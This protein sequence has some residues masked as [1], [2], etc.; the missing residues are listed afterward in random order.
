MSTECGSRER[1]PDPASLT[2]A[3]LVGGLGL[4]LRSVVADR[5]KVMAP[6]AGRPFLASLL[7]QV[8]AAGARKAVLCTG[9]RAEQIE[10]EFGDRYGPLALAYSRETEPL[11]TA[12]AL[13]LAVPRLDSDPVLVLNGDSYC[14][15]NFDLLLAFYR[16]Q[17]TEALLWLAHVHDTARYGRVVLD[18]G[19]AVEQ[20]LEKADAASQGP[21]WIN[22]GVY[23]V[24]RRAL[25]SISAGRPCSLEREVFPSWVGRGLRA[26]RGAGPFIDIG[27]PESY[28]EVESFLGSLKA[29]GTP[30]GGGRER[31]ERRFVLLDRDGV[32]NQERHYL[33]EPSELELLP[34]VI[35]GLRALR[36]LGLGLVVVT[37]QSGVGRGY[38]DQERLD[39][40]HARLRSLLAKEGVSL[41]GI[42]VCPHRPDEQCKC[43]KPEPG[44]G[45]QASRDHAFDPRTAIVVGDKAC[46]IDFGRRLG[47]TAILVTTGYGT[48]SA[49]DPNVKPDF[50]ANDLVEVARLVEG[51]LTSRPAART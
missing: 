43:R 24:S 10:T 11:G 14:A 17:P 39:A 31:P 19:G 46:D 41:D 18:A 5:P 49:R 35:P 20:F 40:I 50:V 12:G 21:G 44:L 22:A 2:A 15:F 23:L 42:Y 27:T 26:F 16:A 37:N 8:I 38:F 4:R 25:E 32:L 45:H 30:S 29:A 34:G 33:S 48:Q 1:K 36:D 9:Y 47:A 3:I 7:D 13:R 28:A 51:L 6:V